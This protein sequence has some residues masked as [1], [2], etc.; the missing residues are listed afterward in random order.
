MY[1]RSFIYGIVLLAICCSLIISTIIIA[2][3]PKSPKT[4][5]NTVTDTYHDVTVADDY[6]WLEDFSD[7]AVKDWNREQNLF[8]RSI[9]DTVTNREII[10]E[11][12]TELMGHVS[13]SYKYFSKVGDY[14][15][16]L[17]LL[18][19]AEHY[20]LV[21]YTS[22][23]DASTERVIVNVDELDKD[24][25]TSI[26][27]YRPSPC[28]KMVA[29]SL[30]EKGSEKGTLYI[31][32]T[33]TGEKLDEFVPHVYGPTT[34]GDA[35]WKKDGSGVYYTRLPDKGERPDEDLLFYQQVYFHKLGTSYKEDRYITG[36]QFPKIA[37]VELEMSGDGKLM[38]VTV[39][40][41]DGGEFEHFI[42]DEQENVTQITQLDDL[43][44]DL[45]FGADNSLYFLSH[46]NS[47]MSKVLHLPPGETDLSKATT[48]VEESDV[49]IMSMYPGETKLYLRDIVGGPNQI[50]VFDLKTAEQF[51]IPSDPISSVGY[52][53]TFEDDKLLF[54]SISYFDPE[55]WFVYDPE[56]N[57]IKSTP[58][59][60]TSPADFSDFVV[61]R[62]FAKSKDGTKVPVNI[63][64]RKDIVKDGNNPTILFGYGGY[65]IS[66]RPYFMVKLHL[67]LEQG[68]IYVIANLRGGGEYGK[69]WHWA[70][71][72]TKKQNVFD[73]FAACAEHLFKFGY[74][75][76]EKLVIRGRSNGGLLMGAAL[77][78]H[79]EYYRGVVST[80]G[81]Y[82]ML[83]VE[84]DPNGEF[85]IP[86]YGTVKNQDHFKA[87]YA[88]S[89][90]H[91]VKPGTKYPSVL[92]SAGDYD[93][94][95]N[96]MQSRKMIA[97][98][99]RET[100]SNNPI[101]LR[102]SSKLG[103]STGSLTQKIEYETD[104]YT[105]IFS[106]LGIIYKYDK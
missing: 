72:L 43:I 99:Q 58:F 82:D 2:D 14:F 8:T 93:G 67:W 101:L 103:H 71:S 23:D 80:V 87:L 19:P 69:E 49:S 86:E 73:D 40:N 96:P 100:S 36:E 104:V 32:N 92:F 76:P 45:H 5:I 6:R 70:S 26:D 9:L 66:I 35:A 52:L 57:S 63:M 18:P 60:S 102:T 85:N 46:K 59:V 25:L 41:G 98:L 90:Y 3:T 53:K 31:F 105:F 56:T 13:P 29:V 38:I 24:H 89:P 88:Y 95:V 42:V 33:E 79:P 106:Q 65:G 12:L 78:Q 94:R 61:Y 1:R 68:G 77:T 55:A 84:L 74:T 64:H 47:P 97:L 15:F 28:G 16:A 50:R 7:Q 27:F 81:I 48:L 75:T 39:A 10:K 30:S 44:P 20:Y 54:R 21:S 91:N 17:K 37:E 83:R 22:L 62:E 51:V 4:K 34:L 11:R